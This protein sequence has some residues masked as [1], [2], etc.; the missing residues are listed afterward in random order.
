MEQSKLD[1]HNVPEWIRATDWLD[2]ERTPEYI[3][4]SEIHKTI[5][6]AYA[7]VPAQYLPWYD[8]VFRSSQSVIHNFSEAIG[9]GMGWYSSAL[10]IARG[11]AYEVAASLAIGPKDVVGDLKGK[12]LELIRLL[13]ARILASPQKPEKT[14]RKW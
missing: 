12:Q 9:K 1:P 5:A 8:Q 13:N 10:M 2:V 3:L 14:W 4:A 6:E 11:E 7:R